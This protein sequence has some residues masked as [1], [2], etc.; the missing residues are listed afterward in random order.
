MDLALLVHEP[1]QF[2][3]IVA[4][5]HFGAYRRAVRELVP[6]LSTLRRER[7]EIAAFRKRPDGA[8]FIARPLVVRQDF[9]G[10][11]AGRAFK[12]AYD[13]WLRLYWAAIRP[14]LS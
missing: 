10:G 11:A 12:A 5:G 2:A 1:I 4:K 9:V 14:L 7:R 8:L 6:W 3:M 13:T